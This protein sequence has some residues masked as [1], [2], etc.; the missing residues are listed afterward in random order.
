MG[1]GT[2]VK[3]MKITKEELR[4][5]IIIFNGYNIEKKKN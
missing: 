5:F 1:Q 3:V 2:R 4:E